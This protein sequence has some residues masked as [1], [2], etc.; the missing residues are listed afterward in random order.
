MVIGIWETET[1]TQL[2]MLYQISLNKWCPIS[3]RPNT[4]RKCNIQQLCCRNRKRKYR[5]VRL[6]CILTC[7][8]S[9]KVVRPNASKFSTRINFSAKKNQELHESCFYTTF[10]IIQLLFKFPSENFI[11]NDRIK[12]KSFSFHFTIISP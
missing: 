8:V 2:S 7:S 9:W 12:K 10:S 11:S 6:S 3:H 4:T 5:I 1:S